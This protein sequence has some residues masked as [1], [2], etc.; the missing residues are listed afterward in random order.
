MLPP[1]IERFHASSGIPVADIYEM[2][3]KAQPIQR[4]GTPQ[5]IASVVR[6]LL[7]DECPFM[8]GAHI[9]VDG[10]YTCQ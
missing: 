1:T 8:T 10:G 7:S 9:S 5:E 6:F 3:K 4:M 2:L